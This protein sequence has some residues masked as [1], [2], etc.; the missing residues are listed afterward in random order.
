MVCVCVVTCGDLGV[1]ASYRLGLPGSPR[2]YFGTFRGTLFTDRQAPY[3]VRT[4]PLA[5]LFIFVG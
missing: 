2:P 3:T 1:K 5:A 4:L